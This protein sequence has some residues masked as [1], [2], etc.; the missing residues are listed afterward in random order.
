MRA[1]PSLYVILDDESALSAG[2]SVAEVAQA[3]CA[4]GARLLQL[5]APKLSA[6]ELYELGRAVAACCAAYHATLLINDRLDV[7][8][9][10]GCGGVHLPE[11]GLPARAARRILGSGATIGRSCHDLEGLKQARHDGASFATLSPIYETASKPGYGPALGVQALTY[12]AT[13]IELPVFALA[14]VSP[15]RVAACKLAGAYGVAVMGGIC[16]HKDPYAA[17][18][19]YLEELSRF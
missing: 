2:H 11:R 6:H 10:L 15:Q 12:A 17:T 14:G 9:A 4:A 18:Q 16:A 1:L 7:A 19:S 8:L 5:R 3:S 13:H